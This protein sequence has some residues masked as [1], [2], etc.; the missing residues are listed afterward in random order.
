M[1]KGLKLQVFLSVAPAILL[2][3]AGLWLLTHVVRDVAANREAFED[4]RNE[5][6]K[7]LM[8][9]VQGQLRRKSDV[10]REA[11]LR[12]VLADEPY[13]QAAFFWRKG[14]GLV[15]NVDVPPDLAKQF[16]P[17][18]SWKEK[19]QTPRQRALQAYGDYLVAW[20]R[21]QGE[22][23][24]AGVLVG[25]P[26]RLPFDDPSMLYGIAGCFVAL[27]LLV[28]GAGTWLLVRAARQA[29]QEAL[30]KTN[31]VSL[32]SHELNTPLTAIIPYADM[33]RKGQ[34]TVEEER[35]EAYDVIA[36]ESVRLKALV[37]E[38]LDFSRLERR[39]KKFAMTDFDVAELIQSVVRLMRG[40][41]PDG[42]PT[43]SAE[44]PLRV[45]A[46]ADAVKAILVNLLDNAAKYA[47][48]APVEV[49][50]EKDEH[51]VRVEVRD[52][53]P[54]LSSEGLRNVF[55]RFW[56]ADDSTTASVGGFGLGLTIARSYAREMGGDLTC[57]ARAE[58]GTVFTLALKE[59][60]NG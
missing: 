7:A 13:A 21:I 16:P 45:H 2:A 6:W 56:R 48:G 3:C 51:G 39:T 30:T 49:A 57:A 29:R 19:G 42:A 25:N 33:L 38:L 50:A 40:R 26:E 58:G 1:N 20:Q 23:E 10:K 47:P 60:G 27:A 12:Q 32:V 31:F 43:V 37:A 5:R 4:M 11:V 52:R 54:G 59:A 8:H 24:V 17:D 14:E 35:Q 9:D 22:K 15:C 46:D 28:A 55:T 44:A 34:I 41:F 36:D 53:G 18:F